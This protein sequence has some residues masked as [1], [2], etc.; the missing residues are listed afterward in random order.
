MN[1]SEQWDRMLRQ[2]LASDAK[3]EEQLNREV[4]NRYKQI[5]ERRSNNKKRVSIGVLVAVLSLVMSVSAFAALKLF[6]P[7]QVAK[8]M[9]EEILA[10][11]FASSEA[12]EIIESVVSGGYKITLHGIVSGAGLVELESSPNQISSEKTYAVVSIA[13]ADGSPMPSTSDPQYG[14]FPFLVSPFIKGLE[15][16]QVN[17]ASMNGSYSEIVLDGVMYRL[18]ECDIVEMF[19]DRGVYLAVIGGQSFPNSDT[20]AFDDRT[21]EISIRSDYEGASALFDLP[22]DKSKA[23][24]V[25]AEAYLRELLK[26]SSSNMEAE[27]TENAAADDGF[28]EMAR[29]SAEWKKKVPEG[30]T[31]PE[32]IQQ[33]TID[34]QGKINYNFDVWDVKVSP[35]LLFPEGQTGDFPYHFSERDG[36][37]YVVVF[38]VDEDSNITG[39]VVVIDS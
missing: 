12:I 39:K 29:K 23:D 6:S 20:I 26:E 35:D 15:P 19:A 9:G 21:G 7:Q 27:L 17:I 34:E 22:L 4:M 28:A 14:E 2:A 11:A 30:K 10:E 37:V 3:P 25:K 32:S 18:I 13:N 24:P 5:S 1:N 8:Q 33:V 38:T 36:K 16:W 31:I